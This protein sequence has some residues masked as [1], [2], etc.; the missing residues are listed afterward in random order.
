MSLIVF[1]AAVHWDWEALSRGAVHCTF[2]DNNR[3]SLELAKTKCEGAE[4]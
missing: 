3:T 4:I 1:A 2:V